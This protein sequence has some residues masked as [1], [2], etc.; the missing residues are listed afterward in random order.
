MVLD[1]YGESMMRSPRQ[2][3]FR[4]QRD[5]RTKMTPRGGFLRFWDG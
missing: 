4:N 5:G 2:Q 3:R 1:T